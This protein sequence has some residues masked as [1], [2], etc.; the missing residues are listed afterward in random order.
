LRAQSLSLHIEVAILA[1]VLALFLPR[2]R[3]FSAWRT[4]FLTWG[5]K[6]SRS[7]ARMRAGSLAIFLGGAFHLVA[8]LGAAGLGPGIEAARPATWMN[9]FCASSNG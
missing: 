9:S 3:S 8:E 7:A 1:Q 6:P 2:P 5:T 4:K